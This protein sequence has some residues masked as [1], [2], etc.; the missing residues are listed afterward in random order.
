MSSNYEKIRAKYAQNPAAEENRHSNGRRAALEFRSTQLLLEPYIT[1]ESDVVEFGCATGYYASQWQGRCKSYLGVDLVQEN[2]DFFN[3]KGIPNAQARQGDATHCPAL[4]DASFDL[5]L[6]LGPMYHLPPEERVLAMAEMARIAKPGAVLAFSFVSQMGLMFIA[7]DNGWGRRKL[8]LRQRLRR[9]HYY[10][11][12]AGLEMLT[13]GTD[14]LRPGLFYFTM[15]EKMEALAAQSGLR[16]LRSA[17]LDF[18][19][20]ERNLKRMDD[21]QYA[22]FLE[23]H[24]AATQSPACAGMSNHALLI[25]EKP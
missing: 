3:A 2:V 5:V 11:T 25:C 19:Y 18:I 20:N 14:D 16:V 23:A 13:T 22:L 24:D 9:R 21:A 6:C 7:M 12:R 17:G 15:P 8:S 10:P 1:A 4:A